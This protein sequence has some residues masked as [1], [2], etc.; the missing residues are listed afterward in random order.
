M[1]KFPRTRLLYQHDQKLRSIITKVLAVQPVS[2]LSEANRALFKQ[3]ADEDHVV[4]TT[5][6]IFYVQGGGQPSDTGIMS[7]EDAGDVTS[8]EVASVRHGSEGCVL[9]LG[10]FVPPDSRTFTENESVKQ[11]IDGEKRDLHSRIHTAGHLLGLAVRSLSQ[12]MPDVTEL[13]AQHYPGSAFVEFQGLIDGKHKGA[14]QA[15]T[16]ELMQQATPVNVHFWNEKELKEKCVIVPDNVALPDGELMRAVE[17]EGAG[18]YPCGGTHFPNTSDVGPI[19]IRK[20][21]RQ[22]GRSK[23]SYSTS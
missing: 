16:N 20:I 21:S 11:T 18:A 13:K 17:I 23:V 5:D 1:N 14:I 22:K 15:K 10:R 3:A 8:F 9:H 12:S 4:V 7:S 6:T 2:A 19:Q